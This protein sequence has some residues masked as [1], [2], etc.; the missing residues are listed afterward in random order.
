VKRECERLARAA[1]NCRECFKL[2]KVKT[3]FIDVAQPRWVGPRYWTRGL[4]RVV[5]LMTNP[6]QGAAH[7]VWAK[8]VRHQIH[9]F[10]KGHTSLRSVLNDQRRA[11]DWS[12]FYIDGLQLDLNEVAFANLA[13]CATS[14]NRYPKTML[15]RCFGW[16]TGPLLELLR[17]HVVLVAGSKAKAFERDLFELLPKAHVIPILHHAHRKGRAAG[18]RELRRVRLALQRARL[19]LR[20]AG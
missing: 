4:F 14:E 18:Q 17:P 2:E 1:T 11:M 12:K 15:Q 16:H 6:G 19:E 10:R 20:Q 5:I 8:E 9:Q 13:W 7:L 3:A